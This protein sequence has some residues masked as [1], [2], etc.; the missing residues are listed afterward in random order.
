MKLQ[1][2][3]DKYWKLSGAQLREGSPFHYP[4]H[5]KQGQQNVILNQNT[6]FYLLKH[7]KTN[8]VFIVAFIKWSL[9]FVFFWREHQNIRSAQQAAGYMLRDFRN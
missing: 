4:V 1:M 2:G 6:H 7:H 3:G 9:F 5:L 8:I